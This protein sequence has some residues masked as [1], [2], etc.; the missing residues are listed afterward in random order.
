[1]KI[2]NKIFTLI[3]EGFNT[4]TL[5]TMSESNIN[6]LYSKVV[7]EQSSPYKS[8][9][10]TTKK[11]PKAIELAKKGVNVNLVEKEMGKTK[12]PWAICTAQCKKEFGTSKRSEW[13]KTQT[14]KFEKCV[15]DIKKE[16]KEGVNSV[17]KFIEEEMNKMVESYLKPS[18]SKRDLLNFVKE[19]I[20]TKPVVKPAKPTTKPTRRDNPFINPNP[21]VNPLP[22]ANTETK[23]VVK[24]AKPTTKPTRR[25]NPFINPNPKVNPLPKAISPE[26]AKNAIIN[27]IMQLL[28]FEN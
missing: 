21:K 1:M 17:D 2:N 7:K 19:E 27:N 6:Y 16:V 23:P 12:N 25:D 24:P 14:K 26:K 5:K 8:G 20:E 10:I 4:K 11:E 28:N 13:S 22:K 18:I 9:T 15:M 3:E